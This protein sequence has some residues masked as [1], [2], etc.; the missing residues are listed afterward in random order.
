MFHVATYYQNP[1]YSLTRIYHVPGEKYFLAVIGCHYPIGDN[2]GDGARYTAY[3]LP[4]PG[5]TPEESQEILRRFAESP[6]GRHRFGKPDRWH[7]P[8]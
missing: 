6:E 4:A 2:R 5:A 8:V 1:P 7:F 3:D